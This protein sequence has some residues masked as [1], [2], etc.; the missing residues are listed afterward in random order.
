MQ[1][2]I[3]GGRWDTLP[4]L[5]WVCGLVLASVGGRTILDP[6]LP[7]AGKISIAKSWQNSAKLF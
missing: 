3:L 2:S 4:F 5:V 7:S 1:N 6:V